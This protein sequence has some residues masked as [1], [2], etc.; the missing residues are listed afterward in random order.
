MKI[1][2]EIVNLLNSAVLA[3]LFAMNRLIRNREEVN[4]TLENHS[5]IRCGIDPKTNK[6]SV[7]I[8]GVINGIIGALALANNVEIEPICACFDDKTGE[9]IRFAK[10]SEVQ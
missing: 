7:G 8:L 4:S 9:L 5:L 3:D 6:P 10:V 1:A 2:D